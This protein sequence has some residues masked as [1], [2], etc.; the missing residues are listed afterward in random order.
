MWKATTTDEINETINN[1]F[2]IDLKTE[3]NEIIT[4][5]NDMY[6]YIKNE[7]G[8]SQSE[9]KNKLDELN[10]YDTKFIFSHNKIIP[11]R[12][13]LQTEYTKVKLSNNVCINYEYY[14][15]FKVEIIFTKEESCIQLYKL[16]KSIYSNYAAYAMLDA[17]KAKLKKIPLIGDF[18]SDLR[19]SKVLST[20]DEFLSTLDFKSTNIVHDFQNWIEEKMTKSQ[21]DLM[22]EAYEIYWEGVPEEKR[23]M[24][25][26]M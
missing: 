21:I 15:D 19:F 11:P 23:G 6:P 17:K 12:H 14:F 4:Y 5:I 1:E 3:F 13:N 8:V 16:I 7:Y 2:N 18:I 25:I 9:V 26:K 24:R 20:A 22:N 10:E